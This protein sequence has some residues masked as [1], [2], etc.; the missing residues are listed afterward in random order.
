MS[1]FTNRQLAHQCETI[2][3]LNRTEFTETQNNLN[4]SSDSCFIKLGSGYAIFA[5][6]GSPLSRA[7]ALGFDDNFS[8]EQVLELEEFYRSNDSPAVVEVSQLANIELTHILLERG[9]VI[10][11]Y[12]NTLALKMECYTEQIQKLLYEVRIVDDDELDHFVST[13]TK[14]FLNITD[15]AKSSSNNI[16]AIQKNFDDISKVFFHQPNSTCFFAYKNN[17]PVGAG[18]LYIR[19]NH[20]LLLATTTLSNHRLK[21]VQTDLIKMRLNF[22]SANNLDMALSVTFPGSISQH[23]LEKMGFQVLYGRITFRKEF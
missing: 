12:T 20:A 13:T 2:M 11:D 23:N 10:L 21:G 1:I 17:I 18:G 19:Q 9:F 4:L 7:T 15:Q 22:I 3:A 8:K 14:G 5:G 16:K 6:M